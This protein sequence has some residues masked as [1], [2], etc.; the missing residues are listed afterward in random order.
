MKTVW[1]LARPARRAIAARFDQHLD[2]HLQSWVSRV[3]QVH[4]EQQFTAAD[5]QLVAD[6]MVR[7]LVRLQSQIQRLQEAIEDQAAETHFRDTRAAL[8]DQRQVA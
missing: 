3:E 1:R 7:E 5:T 4:A 2:C 6:A 8:A